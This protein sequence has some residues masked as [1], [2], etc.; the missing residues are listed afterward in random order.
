MMEVL[1]ES[2]EW[3]LG[4]DSNSDDTRKEQKSKYAGL[5]VHGGDHSFLS[6]IAQ[7]LDTSLHSIEATVTVCCCIQQLNFKRLETIHDIS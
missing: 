1:E 3:L 6:E 2:R 7:A 5:F 4:Q